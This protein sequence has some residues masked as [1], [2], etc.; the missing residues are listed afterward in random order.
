[1]ENLNTDWAYLEKFRRENEQLK[2][3]RDKNRVVFIGDSIIAGWK[4]QSLFR[5]NL[6]FINRGINGQTSSQ[7]LH[8]FQ[9]DVLDLQPKIVVVL[10]GTNDIAE[11]NGQITLLEIQNNFRSM[12]KVAIGNGIPIVLCSLLPVSE[13]YW[14]KKIKPF[15]KINLLNCFLKSQSTEKDIFF[16][17]YYT[18]LT[19]NKVMNSKYSND[20]VHPNNIGYDIMSTR[21]SRLLTE[22]L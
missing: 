2:S 17:D 21:L 5:E 12:I 15:E 20:G 22:I 1:M 10:V 18:L 3:L 16:V 13:Y 9:A 14:N 4:E 19:E 6:H 11:N 7:I 8:R